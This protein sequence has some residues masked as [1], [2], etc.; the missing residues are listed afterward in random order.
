MIITIEDVKKVINTNADDAIIQAFIDVVEEK[1]GACYNSMSN[2]LQMIL[3][4]HL[5]AFFLET[6]SGA[7]EITSR[8]QATGASESYQNSIDRK[9][10]AASKY[11]R[12]V[13]QLDTTGCWTRLINMP[14]GITT[15][16]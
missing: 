14:F 10:L 12:I 7:T 2:S 13:L 6:G 1:L 5:V 4:T 8:T 16:G 9:G 3:K 11:G 15:V